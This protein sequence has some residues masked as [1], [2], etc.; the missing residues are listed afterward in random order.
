MKNK[1]PRNLILSTQGRCSGMYYSPK[2]S[3]DWGGRVTQVQKVWGQPRQHSKTPAGGEKK[4]PTMNDTPVFIFISFSNFFYYIIVALGIHCDIY[5]KFL[6]Y[7]IFEFAPSI[8]FL[9]L[10]ITLYVQ[11]VCL[12]LRQKQS[13]VESFPRTLLSSL[14]C[15]TYACEL[16]QTFRVL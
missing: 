14:S 6:Q 15:L 4:K 1:G 13:K 10:L 9:F 8:T 16:Q 2:Y 7:I 5:K 12:F 3:G 11:Y